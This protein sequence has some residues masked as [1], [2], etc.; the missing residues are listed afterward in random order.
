MF[1][2]AE[3]LDESQSAFSM[4]DWHREIEEALGPVP[5][6]VSAEDVELFRVEPPPWAGWGSGDAEVYVRQW[7]LVR[8]GS[9]VLGHVVQANNQIFESGSHDVPGSLLYSRDPYYLDHPEELAALAGQLMEAKMRGGATDSR[10]QRIVGG[11]IDEYDRMIGVPI[12]S[13]AID[14]REAFM[15]STMFH[16][17]HLP[18]GRLD[19]AAPIPL[20]VS[21]DVE[22][23]TRIIPSK[24]W[25]QVSEIGQQ[26]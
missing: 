13:D 25:G 5:R 19:F 6:E 14:G 22:G 16:R 8:S 23:L 20:L 26:N 3:E 10:F 24:F 2:V 11:L 4:R 1:E 17:K 21:N 7:Q 12:P 18:R 9:V 15:T